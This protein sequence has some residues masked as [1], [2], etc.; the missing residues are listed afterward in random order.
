MGEELKDARLRAVLAAAGATLSA[1]ER[2]TLPKLPSDAVLLSVVRHRGRYFRF[3]RWRGR[4]TPLRVLSKKQVEPLL[5]GL[6]DELEFGKVSEMRALKVYLR[7]AY[8]RLLADAL[9]RGARRLL[10]SGDGLLRYV[11]VH[12]FLQPVSPR[13]AKARFLVSALA[14]A[15]V[16][17]LSALSQAKSSALAGMDVLLPAYGSP[18]LGRRPLSGG[19]QEAAFLE[20]WAKNAKLE[21]KVRRGPAATPEALLASLSRRRWGVH[22][23]GHGIADL[24]PGSPPELLFPRREAGLTVARITAKP[25]AASLVVLA[26]CTTAYVARFRGAGQPASRPS[27]GGSPTA[28]QLAP[29]NLAEALLARGAGAVVAASWNVK[30][31]Q[32]AAQMAQFYSHLR[33]H[34][35]AE[36]LARAQ[37]RRI[38]RLRPPHP[39]YWAFYALYGAPG[40]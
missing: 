4:T 14:I 28:T 5:V 19:A 37:R 7:R 17:S 15:Q 8:D 25:V 30:D 11:P 6:R 33:R 2:I 29:V 23:A 12:A 34:G 39:R 35:A 24:R 13:S 32:S 22:F 9:P 20:R 36:A 38:A 10:L 18:A 40:W 27:Q 21:L 31:R 26:S 1:R 3:R 16:P